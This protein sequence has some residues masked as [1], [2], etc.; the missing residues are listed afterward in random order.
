MSRSCGGRTHEKAGPEGPAHKIR[1][2]AD[3][4]TILTESSSLSDSAEA[5]LSETGISTGVGGS[6]ASPA[7]RTSPS[8]DGPRLDRRDRLSVGSSWADEN[9][10]LYPD[11]C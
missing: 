8:S 3:D 11:R 4:Y 2:K 6:V 9:Q 10:G 5:R 7:S 1:S